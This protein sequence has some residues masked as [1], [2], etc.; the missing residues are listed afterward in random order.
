[1]LKNVSVYINLPKKGGVNMNNVNLIATETLQT[2]LRERLEFVEG[3]LFLLKETRLFGPLLEE[4]VG[5]VE[6][7]KEGL[8]DPKIPEANMK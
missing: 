4:A 8:L 2:G 3:V 1:L 5:N 7:L 6:V